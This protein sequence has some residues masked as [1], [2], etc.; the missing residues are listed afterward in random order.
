MLFFSY[1]LMFYLPT[2]VMLISALYDML[3]TLYAVGRLT[4]RQS[5]MSSIRNNGMWLA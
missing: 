1:I 2:E 5:T 3:H 4:K